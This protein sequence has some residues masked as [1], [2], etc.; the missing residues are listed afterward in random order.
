MDDGL[1]ELILFNLKHD[2]MSSM[3]TI[4]LQV[5]IFVLKYILLR[6][7]LKTFGTP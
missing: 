3:N 2:I 7:K 1:R 6:K 4:N 5:L